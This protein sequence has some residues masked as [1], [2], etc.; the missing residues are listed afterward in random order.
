[1][2]SESKSKPVLNVV[3]KKAGDPSVTEKIWSELKLNENKIL[4]ENASVKKMVFSMI[5]DNQDIF[6]T[7][8]TVLVSFTTW[9]NALISSRA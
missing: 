2:I 9:I 7:W 4:Q 5:N 3:N 6:T 1:M 8:I